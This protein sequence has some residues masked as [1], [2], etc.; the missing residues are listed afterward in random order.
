M[1]TIR[2]NGS[3]NTALPIIAATLLD[4]RIYR[5]KNI[6]MIEDVYTCLNVL[7]QFN[8]LINFNDDNE[9]YIDTTNM[10]LPPK[11]EYTSNTRGTYYFICTSLHYAESNHLEFMLGN[12]CNI[13]NKNRKIDYHLELIALSGKEYTYH[14]ATDSLYTHGEFTQKDVYYSFKK[15][16]IG[17]TINALFIFSKLPIK[18]VFENYAKDPYIYDVIHFLILMGFDI[19]Y[20]DKQIIINNGADGKIPI[21]KDISYS[22]IMDPIE[23]IS[24]IIYAGINLQNNSISPYTISPVN[25]THLGQALPILKEIGIELVETNEEQCYYIKKNILKPFTITTGYF[26]E[27]YTDIQPFFCLLALFIEDGV[28]DINETI[29]DNRFN[30]VTEI[31]KLGY[32]I[33]QNS[34]NSIS[35]SSGMEHPSSSSYSS[36]SPLEI[37]CTDLR[38]GMAVYMLLLFKKMKNKFHFHFHFIN[39]HIID[40][41]YY[42]YENNMNT[43]LE[44]C[45]S[46]IIKTNYPTAPLSNI[47]I[48]GHAQYYSVF[49]NIN[50]LS[51][52]MRFC[53]YLN[54]KFKLIG[55]GYNIY[56]TDYF[57][58]LIIKNNCKYIWHEEKGEEH[59]LMNV[60]SGTD[61]M[62]LVYYC[63]KY[64][65]DIAELAGI[66]GTVGGSIY[67]NAGAYGVEISKFIHKCYIFTADQKIECLE[68]SD[69]QFTYRNSIFKNTGLGSHPSIVSIDFIFERGERKSSEVIRTKIQ[70][71]L[72]IRNEKFIYTNTLGSIFKNITL[73]DKIVY[74]WK[75]IDLI[76]LR[77]KKINSLLITEKHPNIFINVNDETCS[78]K[79]LDDLVN[80]IIHTVKEKTNMQLELEIERL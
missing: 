55:G 4:K 30:Y 15:P 29:W 78:P 63:A 20:D 24:Y 33:L 64:N 76:G 60:S 26:P 10:Q 40:R 8:V 80:D 9:L 79:E 49:E 53:K 31:N 56:F 32:T 52:L 77:G 46:L 48:G 25:T 11:I 35:I 14:D 7:K 62:D 13:A 47:H 2:I 75:L 5:I 6:P 72:K 41:G 69:M 42:N 61:L 74:A 44:S 70:D 67:G 37:N 39:K 3:K 36:S 68:K 54:I 58:G 1:N 57:E 51:A 65:I 71:I 21:K 12:G 27:I 16:S 43:I 23:V 38:G 19:V 59:I 18:S 73:D 22:I 34:V 28:C 45:G 17:A 66:P 50:D